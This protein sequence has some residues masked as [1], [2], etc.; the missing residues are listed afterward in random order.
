M[1]GISGKSVL[2]AERTY[3]TDPVTGKSED[4]GFV[5]KVSGVDISPILEALEANTI[6]VV[7]PLGTGADFL[8]RRQRPAAHGAEH[9]TGQFKA[10]ELGQNLCAPAN[11]FL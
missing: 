11:W 3:S 6:P 5:G 1:R 4:I 2:R 9:A 10:G 7:T 8:R